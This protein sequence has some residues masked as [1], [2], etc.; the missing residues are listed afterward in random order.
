MAR[1]LLLALDAELTHLMA[2]SLATVFP[3]GVFAYKGGLALNDRIA[4]D[5]ARW[6]WE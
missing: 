2:G 4:L 5:R 6:G 1:V 3:T